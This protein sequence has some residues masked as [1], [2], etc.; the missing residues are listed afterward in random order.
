MW[1]WRSRYL[2]PLALP[3]EGRRIFPEHRITLAVREI[4]Q[5]VV[6]TSSESDHQVNSIH[7]VPLIPRLFPRRTWRTGIIATRIDELIDGFN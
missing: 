2:I 4:T 7:S 5:S 3:F 6:S 1:S